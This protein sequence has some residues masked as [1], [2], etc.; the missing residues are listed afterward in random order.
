MTVLLY[1]ISTLDSSLGIIN[2]NVT[3]RCEP[4]PAGFPLGAAVGVAIAGV[5]VV[6]LVVGSG[7][8]LCMC[9]RLGPFKGMTSFPVITIQFNKQGKFIRLVM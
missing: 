9:C 5:I 8:L 1:I 6:V 2:D 3:R 7:L 4:L